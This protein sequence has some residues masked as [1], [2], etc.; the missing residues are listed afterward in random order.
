MEYLFPTIFML[1][2]AGLIAWAVL[3]QRKA[4]ATKAW[5]TTTGVILSSQLES[6]YSRDSDGSSSITY[7]PEVEYSYT[8]DG[9]MRFSRQLAVG[10]ANYDHFVASR[11]LAPYPKGTEVTVHYD[12]TDPNNAILE[13]KAAGGVIL[14]TIGS[15][16]VAFGLVILIMSLITK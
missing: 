14:L 1:V 16:F 4:N 8:V 11:K 5:P 9:Q 7:S 15:I 13:T 12:P 6:H 10:N 3:Q 2:G